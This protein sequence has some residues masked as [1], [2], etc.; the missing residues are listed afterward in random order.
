[1]GKDNLDYAWTVNNLA[2]VYLERGEYKKAEQL[3]IEVKAIREKLLG[4]ESVDYASTLHN[5][6]LLYYQMSNFQKAEIYYIEARVIREKVLG[7][8]NLDYAWTVNNL[9]NVYLER[10]EYKKAEQL[11]FEVKAIREKLLGNES[12]DYAY[13]L[14]NIG[15]IYN[16]TGQY[17]KSE[18]YYLEAIAI[19]EKLFGKESL[20]YINCLYNLAHLYLEMGKY[21]KPE[22]YFL[23]IKT[24]QEKKF[25]KLHANYAAC[26]SSLAIF[27]DE[28]GDQEK[29]IPLFIE[30][31]AIREKIQDK[32]SV[33]YTKNLNNLA[34][35]YYNK[36]DIENAISFY[37]E[38]LNSQEILLGK[39]HP[40]YAWILNNLANC[41]ISINVYDKA[42]LLHLEAKAIREKLLGK[43]SLDYANSLSNLSILNLKMGNYKECEPLCLEAKT[44]RGKIL[45][46]SHP[47]YMT[48]LVILTHLYTVIG[49]Y[50]K[51]EPLYAEILVQQNAYAKQALTHLSER[52]LNRFIHRFSEIEDQLLSYALK[53]G[54]QNNP[55][56]HLCYDNSLFYKGFLLYTSSRIQKLAASNPANVEKFNQLKS[57][58]RRL[59]REYAK[60]I[61]ERK[62]VEALETQA[63]DVEK[64]LAGTV[65]GYGEAMKQV[66]WQEVQQQLRPDEAAIEFVHYQYYTP[67]PTD[68]VMYAA[69]LLRPG[70][71]QPVF[72]PLFEEKQLLSLLSKDEA[73]SSST[74]FAQAYSRGITPAK[75]ENYQGLYELVWQPLDTLLT[76][77]KTVYYS[78]SGAIHRLNLSA[79]AVDKINTLTDRYQLVRLGSTR[80]LVVADTISSYANNSAALFG[81]IVYEADTTASDRDSTYL[82]A[83]HAGSLSFA[84]VERG[85]DQ[86]G[87]AGEH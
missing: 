15:L 38:A 80:S 74:F 55:T 51:V 77:V 31:K 56:S 13:S 65:A 9:A 60:P 52:E 17:E 18:S 34:N 39:D 84:H 27:Y 82:L 86:R 45:G 63:N 67:N 68:S 66:N 83:N 3:H 5:L 79:I 43:E 42:E 8:D 4:K 78:P 20:E 72:V 70:D 35:A 57:C 23:H 81:G 50:D 19:M 6:G 14:G 32:G 2:N 73:T 24:I 36:G 46:N 53:T 1:M 61:A 26:L 62:D 44:I 28:M 16:N 47:D 7:K 69:L 87:K 29:A 59:A 41:Y 71:S 58:H 54:N 12:Y 40:E 76:G 85:V 64:D 21:D 30:A 25:G 48:T 37:E 11:H 10:G 49:S 22:R 33:A 75:K